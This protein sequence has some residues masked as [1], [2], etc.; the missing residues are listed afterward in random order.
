MLAIGNRP[1]FIMKKQQQL[2]ISEWTWDNLLYWFD[3]YGVDMFP[4][5]KRKVMEELTEA[6]HTIPEL[7]NVLERFRGKKSGVNH[8]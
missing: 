8:E 6:S 1:I 2:A 7:K 3:T 5:A 4:G